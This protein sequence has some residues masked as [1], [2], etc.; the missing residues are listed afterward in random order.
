[1]ARHTPGI[2]THRTPTPIAK[3]IIVASSR[4][5]GVRS[6]AHGTIE[7][8]QFGNVSASPSLISIRF[9]S[10][11]NSTTRRVRR[12]S[13]SSVAAAN[14]NGSVNTTP[15]PAVA[16]KYQRADRSRPEKTAAAPS[17]AIR[18]T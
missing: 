8:T 17:A 12:S 16:T 15:M 9:T 14:R 1:M 3:K 11:R 7:P 6:A 4:T 10:G 2:P 5:T 13:G 18:T